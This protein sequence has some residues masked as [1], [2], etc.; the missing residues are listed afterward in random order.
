MQSLLRRQKM[1]PMSVGMRQPRQASGHRARVAQ[2]Q[3]GATGLAE[4]AHALLQLD[5]HA[6][7]VLL[8]SPL[9]VRQ[10]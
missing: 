8:P 4:L 2:Q 5:A 7:L 3:Q 10:A 1:L 6:F 9:Q